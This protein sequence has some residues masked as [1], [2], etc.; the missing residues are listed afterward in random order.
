MPVG[1]RADPHRHHD[2]AGDGHHP[3]RG[4]ALREDL[5][6]AV[7]RAPPEGEHAQ[8]QRE[9]RRLLEI[10]PLQQRGGNARQQQPHRDVVGRLHA[11]KQRAREHQ[12]PEPDEAAGQV[13]E[14]EHRERQEAVEVGQALIH[15]R[16]RP[17]E[18]EQRPGEEGEG[19]GDLRHHRGDVGTRQLLGAHQARPLGGE[20]LAT[21]EHRAEDQRREV[22]DRPVGKERAE[23][24]LGGHVRHGEQY[25]R[26]EH[27]DAAGHVTD[28]AGDHGGR[29]HAEEADEGHVRIRRQQ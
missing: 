21:K 4:E 19:A 11:A 23:H 17:G 14:L 12:E 22:V 1:E 27:P 2:H 6:G 26:L 15:R 24:R 7:E 16:R 20:F 8:H 29:V 10:Q 28:D 13:R 25:D 5:R 3:H 18:Q 9:Q